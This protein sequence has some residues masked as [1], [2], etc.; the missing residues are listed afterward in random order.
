MTKSLRYAGSGWWLDAILPRSPLWLI[1]CAVA[2]PTGWIAICYGLAYDRDELLATHDI[3][4]QLWFFPLHVICVRLL[5]SLWA[6]RIDGACNGLALGDDARRRLRRGALGT[7]ASVGAIVACAYFIF[8]DASFGFTTGPSGQIPFDD[9]DM[10]D[11]AALGRP[12]HGMMLGMWCL[13]WLLFGYLLWIQVWIL[14]GWVREMRRAE[15]RPHLEKILVGDGYRAAFRLFSKTTTIGLVFALGNLGFIAYT[16]ELIPRE[17]V[18][19]EGA[20]DFLREMSD[21]LSTALLFVLT[22]IAVTVFVR[23]LRSKLTRAVNAQ[24]AEAGE[25]ALTSRDLEATGD[26]DADLAA[27]RDR[28]AVQA[29]LIRTIVFQREVDSIGNR[30]MWSMVAKAMIPL[31]TTVLKMRKVLGL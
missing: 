29:E 17:A 12:V 3:A 4:G 13:E 6:S 15:L 31:V 22:L 5:G 25:R 8:R 7:W 14:A 1:V 30:T 26:S 21:L 28:V 23:I 24:L 2:V 20:G 10:W 11:F 19:I 18:V 9:P 27:L 16:G